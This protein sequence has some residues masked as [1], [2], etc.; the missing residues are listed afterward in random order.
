[1]LPPTPTA[2][3]LPNPADVFNIP[4]TDF[5]VWNF[6]DESVGLWNQVVGDK[7]AILQWIVILVVVFVATLFII[8][9]IRS[10]S[11]ESEA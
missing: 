5:A 4:L 2:P 7:A 6:A 3:P 9:Q 8:K 11:G 10:L 1:M